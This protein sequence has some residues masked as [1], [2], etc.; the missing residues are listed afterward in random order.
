MAGCGG[1][2]QIGHHLARGLLPHPLIIP[3]SVLHNA[4]MLERAFLWSGTDKTTGGKC[5]VNWET[6]CRPTDLG[7]LGVLHL[8]KF[9]RALRLRW[10]WFEWTDP[11]KIWVGMG[12]PCGEA[13]MDLFYESTIIT[14]GNGG[15]AP[16]WNSP[17]LQGVKSK[18]IATLIH[19]A[20]K[21]KK[22][23]VSQALKD[24]AWI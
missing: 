9:A 24:D 20:S 2:G 1:F 21:W 11:D 23:S 6:V 7:G 16:F 4:N 3:P 17:W 10:P 13:D 18:G 22:W 15:K 8:E 19:A 5:K 12:N 14:I